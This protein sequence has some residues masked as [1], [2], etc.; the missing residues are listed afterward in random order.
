MA[1]TAYMA[2]IYKP[3]PV[4]APD[5]G[6][7][8]IRTDAYGNQHVSLVDPNGT[9]NAASTPLYVAQSEISTNASASSATTVFS[10]DALY[11]QSIVV[12]WT[13]V[14]S[15]NTATYEGSLDAANWIAV[16]MD[17]AESSTANPSTAF[18]LSTS[19]ILTCTLRL[20]YFRVRIST[21]GSGTPTCFYAL[22]ANNNP[23][24]SQL[25]R[26]TAVPTQSL[27]GTVVTEGVVAHDAAISGAGNPIRIGARAATANFTA[28]ATGDL[29]DLVA[30]TVGAQVVKPFSIP[31]GDWSY[32]AAASGIVNT[33]TAVTIKAA[34]GAGLR[35]YITGID[36]ATDGA[37]GAATEVAVRDGAAG[38]VIWRMKIGTTGLQSG[39]AIS[40]PTPLK[41]TAN[42]LLEVVTLT[43]SVTGAV[44][45][46]ATGYV[47]P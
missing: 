40:F 43:A 46:N 12:Q 4:A 32:A 31:E 44:Y 28:V 41:S 11:Y 42:T 19:H 2:G 14:G 27:A 5:G 39:R 35:N 20:R 33:T 6:L 3:T 34:A 7:T 45:F 23:Q 36:L 9:A 21:Y 25:L 8:E 17:R 18:A 38:T 10:I 13:S 22:R 15:G 1:G 26:G 37:L 30:T 29:T 47:A 24:Q 16:Q